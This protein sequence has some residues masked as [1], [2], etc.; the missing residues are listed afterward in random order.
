MAA[1]PLAAARPRARAC[2]MP[3]A[4][5]KMDPSRF[6]D[7]A[8]G[9]TPAAGP[10]GPGAPPDS[11]GAGNWRGVAAPD[12]RAH[13]TP[14]SSRRGP[15]STNGRFQ[16]PPRS[17]AIDKTVAGERLRCHPP[18]R[19]DDGTGRETANTAS[20]SGLLCRGRFGRPANQKPRSRSRP[21]FR[22]SVDN[23][24]LTPPLTARAPS[25]RMTWLT[26]SHSAAVQIHAVLGDR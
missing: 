5:R 8:G 13:D 25:A 10:D 9:G 14:S 24:E 4:P 2:N 1:R 6:D 23:A 26:P 19:L 17:P 18:S 21:G 16:T 12:A 11:A 22:F 3:E 7:V 20:L 15:G